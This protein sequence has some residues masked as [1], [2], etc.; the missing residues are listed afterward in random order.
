MP[1]FPSTTRWFP[2]STL[3]TEGKLDLICFFLANSN[4]VSAFSVVDKIER[5]LPFFE[6]RRVR[7]SA[8]TSRAHTQKTPPPTHTMPPK[9]AVKKDKLTDAEKKKIKQDNKYVAR[10]LDHL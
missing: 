7:P 10:R 6:A 8:T 5:V 3:E 9:V 4:F 2:T 1:C